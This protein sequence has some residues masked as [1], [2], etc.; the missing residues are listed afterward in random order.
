MLSVDGSKNTSVTGLNDPHKHTL[1]PIVTGASVMAIKYRDGVMMIADTMAS[2]GN[3]QR[4]KNVKRI[5]PFG[6]DCLVGYSG[7]VSDMQSINDTLASLYQEDLD[8]ND[9]FVKGPSE[10]FNY[11][12]TVMYNR[13]GKGNPLWNQI[14]VAGFREGKSFL[15]YVDLIGTSFEENFIATGFGA[16]LGMPLIRERWHADMDEG[17]ARALL[18]DCIRVCYYRD[19]K[20][21]NKVILSKATSDGTLIS[22][23]PYEIQVDWETAN[24][25]LRHPVVSDSS[26]W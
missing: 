10:V 9:G 25:A 6:K 13:R 19:C 8:Q 15:G 14:L 11:L 2:Y 23:E 4:Y 17:E 26:S 12:R 22:E 20:A 16:Y 18:E 24:F 1:Q 3:L 21:F 7:E 5:H